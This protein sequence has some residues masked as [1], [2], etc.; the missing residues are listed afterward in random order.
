MTLTGTCLTVD[1]GRAAVR[2]TRTYARPRE[3]VW[4]YVS[5]PAQLRHWFPSAFEAAELRPGAAIRFYD[6]PHA[7]DTAEATGTVLAVDAPRHLSYTWGADE[8]RLDLEP[9]RDGRTRLTLTNVLERPDTAARNAAGWEVCLTALDAA[10]RGAAPDGAHAGAVA[11]W[12]ELYD[13]YRAAGFPS[14]APVPDLDDL[15]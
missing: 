5:D 7:P 11:P 14:G 8:L 6:D 3:R 4:E 10:D 1:D 15:T 13:A 12:K 9:L 2:L